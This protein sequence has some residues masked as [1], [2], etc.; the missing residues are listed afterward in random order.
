MP[1]DKP[2]WTGGYAARFQAFFVASVFSACKQSPRPPE[3]QELVN[4][5]IESCG[6]PED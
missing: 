4:C 6:G 5:K 2:Q 1:T 3:E